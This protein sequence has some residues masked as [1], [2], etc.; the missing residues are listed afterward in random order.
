MTYSL[1]CTV[2]KR[3]DG[4]INSPTATWT[5]G[6]EAVINGD[7]ISVSTMTVDE[8]SISTLTF[9]PLKTSHDAGYSCVGTLT[10]S[11]LDTLL[12]ISTVETLYVQRE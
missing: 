4:L 9:D 5:T 3:V 6:G 2:S 11:A 10:S 7:G 1:T 8:T 12:M